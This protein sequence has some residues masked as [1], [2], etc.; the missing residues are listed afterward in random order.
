M[1][2]LNFI[3]TD[4]QLQVMAVY[5]LIVVVGCALLY[6]LPLLWPFY[7][8][9]LYPRVL[10]WILPAVQGRNTKFS[11]IQGCAKKFLHV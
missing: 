6:S 8:L 2:H 5:D 4:P 1:N 10:P 11:V 9:Q 3:L 7:N